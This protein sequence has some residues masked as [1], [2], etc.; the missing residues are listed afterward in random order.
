MDIKT[1]LL[2]NSQKENNKFTIIVK[3]P[4]LKVK[5]TKEESIKGIVRLG[6]K[7]KSEKGERADKE[8]SKAGAISANLYWNYAHAGTTLFGILII[9]FSTV[10]SH[11][12]FRFTDLWLGV[13]TSND[14]LLH[15]RNLT[16]AAVEQYNNTSDFEQPL[17]QF[18]RINEYH[19]MV[20]CFSV[21]TLMV[22]CL[23]MISRFFI[24][25]IDASRKLHNQMFSR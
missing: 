8:V 21:L 12:L 23:F 16:N 5:H 17:E 10:T 2:K 4:D 7:D 25:C 1:G 18:N 6:E 14:R 24:M 9:L 3:Q 13:W 22:S 11:A 15:M 20:Y 19:L